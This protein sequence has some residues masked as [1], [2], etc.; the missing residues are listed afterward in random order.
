MNDRNPAGNPAQNRDCCFEFMLD[1]TP[2]ILFGNLSIPLQ[3]LPSS[4]IELVGP[5][6]CRQ[7][8][9]ILVVKSFSFLSQGFLPRPS[10][11]KYFHILA[12][13]PMPMDGYQFHHSLVLMAAE[14]LAIPL[15][16]MV[17]ISPCLLT[18]SGSV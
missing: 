2:C 9:N 8:S 11:E 13:F 12:I 14:Y 17:Q 18:W 1:H 16:N 10:W 3:F 6:L 7:A 5:K 15:S 4:Q